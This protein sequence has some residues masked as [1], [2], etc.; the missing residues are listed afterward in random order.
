MGRT[1]ILAA[2][3]MIGVVLPVQ[4]QEAAERPLMVFAAASTYGAMQ[5]IQK[6][7]ELGG[8]QLVVV[9]GASSTLAR[10]IENGAPAD[11]YIS[12]NPAWMD[13]VENL[14][15]IEP[16]SRTNVAENSLIIIAP[17]MPAQ[18]SQ[19]LSIKQAID[20]HLKAGRIAMADPAHVPA[21]IYAK[22]ALQTL[23]L[24][25][26][27]EPRL[28]RTL[29]D[30]RALHLVV[31]QTA[32]LGIVYASDEMLDHRVRKIATFPSASHSAIVY[33]AAV[34]IGRALRAK[35]F[36]Q[37]LTSN[38][39]RAAFKQAGFTPRTEKDQQP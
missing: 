22:Q 10:Q 28:A 34:L 3:L 37:L 27:L 8:G 24:W 16:T 33:P 38:E 7:Y 23:G 35:V 32:P 19:S 26:Q 4:A 17:S 18:N 31:Q 6:L 9:H 30:T 29:D 13:Y 14:N 15:L 36:M 12:A 20:R 25:K 2:A 5:N 11:V 21:G 39:G 1:L